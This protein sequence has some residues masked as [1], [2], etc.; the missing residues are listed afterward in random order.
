MISYLQGKIIFQEKN[1]IVLD[2]NGVG[3]KIFLSEKTSDK[4]PDNK[5]NIKVFTYLYL[6]EDKLELY[7]F[8]TPEDL[9]FFEFLNGISGIGPKAALSLSS[10]SPLENL[11]KV[12][13][14]KDE[15]FYREIKGIGKKKMQ[16]I[17]LELTGK[18]QEVGKKQTLQEGEAVEALTSL[19][20]S[21]AL[22]KETLS[23]IPKEIENAEQK[24]KEA[25]KILGK[26]R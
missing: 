16:K 22:A 1:C 20:F 12:I 25:L 3:F 10:F 13:E 15:R 4:I 5:K 6:R 7:G 19:G 21:S 23:K 9:R 8:L 11:K 18:I 14:E 2:V 26:T 17:L 24:V